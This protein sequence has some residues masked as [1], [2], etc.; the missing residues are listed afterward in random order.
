MN[1][2]DLFNLIVLASES[3][4]DLNSKNESIKNSLITIKNFDGVFGPVTIDN[5]GII[6]FEPAV[7]IIKEG[8]PVTIDQ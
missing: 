6:A 5:E 4:K 3:A 2:Y 1:G 8:K 7:K